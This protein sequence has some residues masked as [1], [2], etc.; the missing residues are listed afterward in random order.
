LACVGEPDPFTR[1]RTHTS[2]IVSAHFGCY[3]SK[4]FL[5]LF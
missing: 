4:C 5:L 1:V 3:W 2:Y